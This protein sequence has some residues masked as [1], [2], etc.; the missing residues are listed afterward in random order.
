MSKKVAVMQPYLFPYIGYF[1]LIYA[2]DCFINYDDVKYIKRGWINRNYILCNSEPLLFTMPLEK[3]SQNKSIRDIS[4]YDDASW[5]RKFLT[6]L[7]FSYK[8]A[9]FYKNIITLLED[10]LFFESRNLSVFILNSIKKISEYL[11]IPTEI[12]DSSSVF[13][14]DNLKKEKRIIDIC[15]KTG[16]DEYINPAGGIELYSKKDFESEGIKIK[17]LKPGYISYK[18][19]GS[20]FTENLSI[21]DVLMFNPQKKV[22]EFLKEFE[23]TG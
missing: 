11:S 5:K 2:C 16:A 19:F 20:K 22:S 10:I 1:Q 15:R 17:F 18:Q 14:N 7:H 8:N 6:T 23:L 9:E 21:I 12:T 13:N 3:A 4:I